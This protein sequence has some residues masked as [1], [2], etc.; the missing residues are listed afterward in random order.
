MATDIERW[1]QTYGEAQERADALASALSR[2]QADIDGLQAAAA[3]DLARVPVEDI[4]AV[5]TAKQRW[6]NEAGGLRRAARELERRYEAAEAQAAGYQRELYQAR[7]AAAVARQKKN[8]QTAI[9]GLKGA[10]DVTLAEPG[11]SQTGVG[12]RLRELLPALLN[13]SRAVDA[14]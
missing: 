13:A 11:A 9:D 14:L 4:R 5:A 6:E 1:E 2:L 3:K 10:V 7:A 12:Q 8:L